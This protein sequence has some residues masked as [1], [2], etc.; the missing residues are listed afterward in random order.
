MCFIAAKHAASSFFETVPLRLRGF[1]GTFAIC[2][3]PVVCKSE[4]LTLRPVTLFRCIVIDDSQEPR[5][6]LT[7]SVLSIIEKGFTLVPVAIW[8]DPRVAVFVS[9]SLLFFQ[10][11][12]EF[13]PLL[14]TKTISKQFVRLNAFMFMLVQQSKKGTH[15]NALVLS[16][17]STCCCSH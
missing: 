9:L 13:I 4:D 6:D 14:L 5:L 2:V 1:D 16:L 3:H 17:Y 8:L 15:R 7:S 12:T 10:S 11:T